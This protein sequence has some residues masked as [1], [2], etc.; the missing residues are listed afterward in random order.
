MKTLRFGLVLS[1][2]AVLFT[3]AVPF[4]SALT[5]DSDAALG[6]TGERSETGQVDPIKGCIDL[7]CRE[8]GLDAGECAC[9]YGKHI[10][11]WGR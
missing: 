9:K 6:T 3:M 7:F 11:G 10:T 4:A 5:L 8:K 1:L 2:V